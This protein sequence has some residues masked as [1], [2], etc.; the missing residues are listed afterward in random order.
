MKMNKET[1]KKE[2]ERNKIGGYREW[3][4]MYKKKKEKVGCNDIENESVKRRK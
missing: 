4:I 2:R 3:E 1:V